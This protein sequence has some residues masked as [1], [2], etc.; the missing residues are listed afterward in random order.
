MITKEEMRKKAHYNALE[1]ARVDLYKINNDGVL[2]IKNTIINDYDKDN[3]GLYIHKTDNYKHERNEA[4]IY[5]TTLKGEQ[6]IS[7]SKINITFFNKN[8]KCKPYSEYIHNVKMINIDELK[9]EK[10]CKIVVFNVSMEI[11][12]QEDTIHSTLSLYNYTARIAVPPEDIE[13]GVYLYVVQCLDLSLPVFILSKDVLIKNYLSDIK[14]YVYKGNIYPD[15]Y[16]SYF[17]PYKLEKRKIELYESVSYGEPYNGCR[18]LEFEEDINKAKTRYTNNDKVEAF[19]E[20]G[21]IQEVNV[22]IDD[23]SV[24]HYSRINYKDDINHINFVRHMKDIDIFNSL[25]KV[26]DNVNIETLKSSYPDIINILSILPNINN[27]VPMFFEKLS[28]DDFKD[29]PYADSEIF[30]LEWETDDG[31]SY[32]LILAINPDKKYYECYMNINDTKD[33]FCFYNYESHYK[34]DIGITEED[35]NICIYNATNS[36]TINYSRDTALF[37]FKPNYWINVDK[38][39]TIVNTNFPFNAGDRFDKYN[40]FGVPSKI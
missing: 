40:M 17:H 14:N 5:Y 37:T 24:G 30:R 32:K 34:M 11:G 36:R 1:N 22:Y 20:G 26:C 4:E 9:G 38:S 21:D 16:N 15:L 13:E 8:K 33:L 25:Y 27:F 31:F 12:T 18:D 29:T 35:G 7:H 6:E 28:L 10:D 3:N 39:G 19:N 23:Y 2:Y